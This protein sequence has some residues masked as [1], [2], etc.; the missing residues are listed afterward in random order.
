MTDA[1]NVWRLA[2]SV[3]DLPLQAGPWLRRKRPAGL[4]RNRELPDVLLRKEPLRRH[5]GE[6]SRAC[7]RGKKQCELHALWRR[8]ACKGSAVKARERVES[9]LK[10]PAQSGWLLVGPRRR[11]SLAAS[12]G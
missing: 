10:M 1:G 4:G 8:L 2:I 6:P 11:K 7:Q 5:H 3:G 12:I 9:A